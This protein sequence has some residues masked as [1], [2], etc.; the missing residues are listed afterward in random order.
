MIGTRHEEYKQRT[1]GLPF[2]LNADLKRS[3]YNFSKENNWH[4]NIEIQLCTNGCGTVILDGEKYSFC[5]NDIVVVNSNVI[6]YT[7]TDCDLTY[8]C[9]IISTDFCNQSGV[10]LGTVYFEPFIKNPLIV[11]LLCELKSEYFNSI[12][13]ARIA[14]LNKLLLEILIIL[15]ENH[16]SSK[17]EAAEKLKKFET[18]KAAISYIRDNYQNKI[19]LDVLAKSV[20]CDKYTLCKEFKKLTGQ[21]I[22]ENINSFRC[23]KAIDFL[24]NGYSVTEAA[25]ACGFDNLSFFTKT[26]KKHIGKIPSEYKK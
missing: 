26:F 12:S 24:S 9:I 11:K 25:F 15:T 4:E 1:D 22:V 16:S 17:C 2:V 7:G 19:T 8:D 23:V 18:V 6:H 21:T 14:I 20:L 5:K 3:S 10:N 13:P